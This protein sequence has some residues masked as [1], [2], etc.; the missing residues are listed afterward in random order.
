MLNMNNPDA[1]AAPMRKVSSDTVPE[2]PGIKN[3]TTDEANTSLARSAK[4]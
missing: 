1:E 3:P 4:V 2:E